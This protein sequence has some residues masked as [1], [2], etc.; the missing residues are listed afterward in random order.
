MKY[1]KN[2]FRVIGII[3]AIMGLTD[4]LSYEITLPIVNASLGVYFIIEAQESYK[5]SKKK[6][7]Y[8]F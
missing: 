3:F 1:I 4:I 5:A 2:L 7:Q 6:K 8:G